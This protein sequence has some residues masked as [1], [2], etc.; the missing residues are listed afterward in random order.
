MLGRLCRPSVHEAVYTSVVFL[1]CLHVADLLSAGKESLCGIT[2]SGHVLKRVERD[3]NML[4]S[5]L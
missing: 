5:T 1:E 4:Q 2:A 3:T